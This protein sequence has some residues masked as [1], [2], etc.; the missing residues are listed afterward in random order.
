[1]HFLAEKFRTLG[2]RAFGVAR[3]ARKLGRT[4][5]QDADRYLLPKLGWNQPYEIN[6]LVNDICNSRCQMC[7]IWEQKKARELSPDEWRQLLSDP[8][9]S[10]VGAIGF[11]GG[12]PTL[13]A[14]LP[15]IFEAA[16]SALPSVK[17]ISM[18][19]NAIREKDVMARVQ[20]CSQ[21]CASH[22]LHFTV[23][24]S[25][26]GVGAV[27]DSVRGRAGNFA[28][29]FACLQSFRAQGIST[30]FGCTIT[31]TNVQQV[32]DLLDFAIA[33]GFYGRFRIA[34]FIER[35]Y[36]EGQGSFIRNF[37]PLE[38]YHLA[39][40]YH[41][42][43]TEFETDPKFRKTYRNIRGM[44]F[45]G[46]KR[47]I[48]CPYQTRGMVVTSNG[49][50]L[51]CAPK[52]PSIGN[53]LEGRSARSL[54]Q[55][56]RQFLKKIR[57]ESCSTCIH[58]Y[59]VPV[60]AREMFT[61][62]MEK[63]RRKSTYRIRALIQQAK[64]L[65]PGRQT[66]VPQ[67]CKRILI[68][69]WYGTETAGDKAILHSIITQLREQYGAGQ[70]VISSLFPFIT[71]WTV[72]EMQLADV[73]IVETCSVEFQK[74]CANADLVVMGGGPLMDIQPIDHVLYAFI[75][76][77]KRG[78]AAWICSCGYGPVSGNKYAPAVKELIRLATHVTWRDSASQ[79][80]CVALGRQDS[81][82]YHDPAADYVRT[83]KKSRPSTPPPATG[84]TPLEVACFLRD[85]T[86]EYFPEADDPEKF[87]VLVTQAREQMLN[88]VL[89]L[90]D[91]HGATVHF[92]AMHH[93][94]IGGDDRRLA[95]W[96]ERQ[97]AE[98]RPEL[99]P[100]F[101]M[102]RLPESP[103]EI[104]AAMS[105]SR[106]NVCMRFHSVVFAEEL[107]TSYI[108]LDYTSGGKILGFL[109]DRNCLSR[110]FSFKELLTGKLPV[111]LIRSALASGAGQPQ[112]QS[113]H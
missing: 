16:A 23:M 25:L 104:L 58:D 63:R 7:L 12:E 44:I 67:G 52:S 101:L 95:R 21:V 47:A 56:N 59:H 27:H 8:F 61:E 55:A 49:S 76:A 90:M 81:A 87:R 33:N 102:S 43:E 24:V 31:K 15:Q 91:E 38:T 22:N 50:M 66:P 70:I 96:M 34:E 97:I 20:A 29:A 83:W 99:S 71:Q 35:L 107:G 14:D 11:T 94:G 19:T 13:R 89:H 98:R 62:L 110:Y 4:L 106:L 100:R 2:S 17:G 78:A 48:C 5:W 51:F 41:R 3:L 82:L 113:K 53:P 18:I 69:G 108:A 72:Q 77:R 93:F 1:M 42:L 9:F 111:E 88:L 105:R 65:A 75:Q 57:E 84:E 109:K 28:S 46:A 73:S 39:L 10:R 80:A 37:T 45:G 79:S 36:N 112:A 64:T 74:E 26:D 54:Y 86:Q 92:H 30:L 40:F 60:T 6:A 68:V 32:D 85:V 103:A